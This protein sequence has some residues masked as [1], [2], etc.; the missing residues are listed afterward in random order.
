VPKDYLNKGRFRS[1]FNCAINTIWI[2]GDTKYL[3]KIVQT[4][5]DAATKLEKAEVEWVRVCNKEWIRC[6]GK[7]S[8]EGERLG[9]VTYD[10]EAGKL[11]AAGWI[12]K[13]KR[14]THRVGFLGVAG[15][16][17]DTIENGR[18]RLK[19]LTLE[20]HR[21]QTSWLDG[22][23]KKHSAV[24]VEFSTQYH[25]QLAFHGITPHHALQMAPRFTGV[26]PDEVIWQAL[27]YSWWQVAL[28]RYATYAAITGLTVFWA[29]PVTIVGILAQVNVIK[30]L[31]GL[32]WVQNIPQ[33]YCTCA[34]V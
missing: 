23:Y 33:V 2:A 18:K 30:T 10:T 34:I 5:D 3:D 31:P 4:R 21:A 16:K 13:T 24:F 14:P 9:D 22:K 7:T 25:A 11:A 8:P 29:V 12:P 28:R 27:N 17:V 6:G 32:I 26:K 15:R 19:V 20:A 1:L